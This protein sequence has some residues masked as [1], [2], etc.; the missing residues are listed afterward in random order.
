[1]S[2]SGKRLLSSVLLTF[3]FLYLISPLGATFL[4]VVSADMYLIAMTMMG[5]CVAVWVLIRMQ[6]KWVWHTT[7]F[8]LIFVLWGVA[9]ALSVVANMETVRRSLIGLWYMLLYIGVWYALHD[10]LANR[11]LSRKLLVDAML[12][13]GILIMMFS[14]VQLASQQEYKPVV[15]LIGNPNALGAV[16]LC[17]TPFAVGR[18]LTSASRFGKLSWGIYSLALIANLLL[19]LSRGA[20][21]GMFASL[22]LLILLLLRHY[23]MLSFSSLKMWYQG[24]TRATRTVIGGIGISAL[25]GVIVAGVLLI[26]S[27]SIPAR[28]P[29]LRTRLWNSALLQFAERPITGQGFYTFGHDYGLSI[30]IPN[31]QSHAHAHSVPFNILAEMGLV[32]IAV[33][34]LTIGVVVRLIIQRWSQISGDDRLIWIAAISA[35]LGFGVQHLF[36]L[37]AMM[38]IVA[39]VGLLMLVLVC[40][41][42][43]PESMRAWHKRGHLVGMIVLWVGLLI[44]GLWSGGIYQQYLDAMR[45]SFGQTE[46]RT[47]S[48][49][50]DDLR[51]TGLL[52]DDVI[53][54]DPQMPIYHQQQALVW[55]VL[56]ES[57]DEEAIQNAISAFQTFLELESN[58]SISWA[59]LSALHW[60]AGDNEAAINAIEQ[61]IDRAP[62]YSFY[63][64]TLQFYKD[65]L[66]RDVAIEVPEYQYNQGFA[67][68]E[69]LREPLSMTFLPQLGWATR[70]N[71]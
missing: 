46:D 40:A 8:D 55:G 53:A 45:I 6:G 15:S 42:D 16:L 29:E 32:G 33:F 36:D 18:A 7:A 17:L 69:F 2:A 48:E 43:Q 67:S 19:T 14:V 56:A 9:F 11:G 44:T 3:L 22:A 51:E 71:N 12:Y 39:L 21:L 28:R 49:R 61:A 47:E 41:S 50:L 63:R 58:H 34:L 1:M 57:G 65:E 4:G 26:N 13:A 62:I 52:L 70:A 25:I 54:Q 68:F 10:S 35:L 24:R 20:W 66:E 5:I 64:D 23:D 60:Q 38:P 59:N 37:P 27:F 30:S 31:A